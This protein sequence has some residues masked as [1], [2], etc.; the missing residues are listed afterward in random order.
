MRNQGA[1]QVVAMEDPSENSALDAVVIDLRDPSVADGLA[2]ILDRVSDFGER[3]GAAEVKAEAAFQD[4][5]AATGR[6]RSVTDELEFEQSE[7]RRLEVDNAELRRENEIRLE[8]LT[9]LETHLATTEARAAE[10]EARSAET[11]ANLDELANATD[12]LIA[13][14][15]TE[16][17]KTKKAKHI[18]EALVTKRRRR[19]YERL[20]GVS[21]TTQKT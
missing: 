11:R 6:L 16:L 7:R 13:W 18:L 15:Q 2:S 5:L 8:Q 19:D 20:V 21:E 9:Q 17:A 12:E 3:A 10:W 4:R 1:N 14:L